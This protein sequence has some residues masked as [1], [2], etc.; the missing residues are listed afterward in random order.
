MKPDPRRASERW[1]RQ[2]EHDFNDAQFCASGK[3][4]NV[5][6]FLCQQAAGK[7]LKALLCGY[8][9]REVRGHSAVELLEASAKLAPS[10]AELYRQAALVDRFYIPTRY[11]DGLPGGIPSE[12]YGEADAEQALCAAENILAAVRAALAQ[13]FPES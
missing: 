13:V 9:A 8:G 7:A 5:A 12:V 6:C 3:R 11:P 10:L 4:Y 2:A 1:L